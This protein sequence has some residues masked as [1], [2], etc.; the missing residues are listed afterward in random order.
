MKKSP[1]YICDIKLIPQRLLYEGI[2]DA[3]ILNLAR[4]IKSVYFTPGSASF[5]IEQKHQTQGTLY[6][7]VFSY[8][9]PGLMDTEDS[10]K[11]SN[12]GAVILKKDDN[13][14]IILYKNDFFS[15][16][17]L[18]LGVDTNPKKTIVKGSI[19]TTEL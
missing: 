3:E 8:S 2:Q 6:E 1:V 14:N 15:N 18:R 13:Q 5:A 19:L 11:L 10:E 17:K 12:T 4:N 16:T 7:K 9:F